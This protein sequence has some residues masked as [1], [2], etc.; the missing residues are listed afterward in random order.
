MREKDTIL[1]VKHLTISFMRYGRGL[2]RD[3]LF[4][5]RDLSLSVRQGEITAVVGASG[6]GKSLLAHGIMGLMPYNC[7]LS[8]EILYKGSPL[9]EARLKKLRGSEISLVPQGISYLDPLM[10]VGD[11][12][13]KGK[14]EKSIREKSFQLLKCY[15]LGEETDRLY[16][17]EIS[18]GMARRVMIASA[19]MERPGLVI[20]DEPTPGLD[21]KTALRVMGHFRE[22]AEMNAGVF[23]ITHDLELA[24]ETADRILIFYDGRVVEDVRPED[25]KREDGLTHSYTKALYRA[26]PQNGF[27]VWNREG[28]VFEAGSR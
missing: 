19:L 1:E 15:G 24:L 16:P 2:N 21:K 10:R 20:A 8:G 27:H 23:I 28:E 6:S 22:M 4:P 17:F 18:G 25:F 9:N 5:I 14:K 3:E 13:R 7:R 11:Q 26:M 12:I